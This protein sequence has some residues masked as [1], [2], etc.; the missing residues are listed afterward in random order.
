MQ[1]EKSLFLNFYEELLEAEAPGLPSIAHQYLSESVEWHGPHPINTLCGHQDIVEKLWI[2]MAEAFS[3]L[4]RRNDILMCGN[5]QGNTWVSAIGH[6]RGR[7]EKDWLSIPATGRQ[8]PIRFGEFARIENGMIQ[9]FRVLFD[10]VALCR[11]GGI[12]LLPPDAGSSAGVPA[13]ATGDGVMTE[14]KSPASGEA[15]LRLIE[16]MIDG[17]MEFDGHDL[18]SMRMERFWTRDMRWYGPAGIGTTQGLDGFQKNHQDP[19][20]EAFPDRYAAPHAALFAEGDYVCVTG[21]P[22][23]VGTH[24]GRY[25]GYPATGKQV[26][27]RVM[28]FWRNEQGLL[29]ENWV[30]IDMLDLFLQFGYDLLGDLAGN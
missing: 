12:E 20:L 2:P 3:A 25:L 23:V 5:Y 19:F 14:P 15:S 26:E 9:E 1:S 6:Y 13:P 29:A 4:E 30:L 18:N 16:E 17:L 28:D 11:H 8:T 21:W 27:M 22:S 10:L 7:F 24:K